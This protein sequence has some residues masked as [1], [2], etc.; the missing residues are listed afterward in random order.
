MHMSNFRL[1][2]DRL[3]VGDLYGNRFSLVIR[4]VSHADLETALQN[5][6]GLRR[7]GFIN[8]F[9]TQRFGVFT[10][11]YLTKLFYFRKKSQYQKCIPIS[12]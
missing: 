12:K 10:R 1:V 11:Y 2:S 9:G 5:F 8:Y 6:E 7:D 4:L 3:R